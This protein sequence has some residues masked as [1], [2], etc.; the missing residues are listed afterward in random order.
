LCWAGTTRA[1]GEL[2]AR[3]W[4]SVGV[5]YRV[6]YESIHAARDV[7]VSP[8]VASATS[9]ARTRDTA[10]RAA[11]EGGGEPGIA[12]GGCGWATVGMAR[13]RRRLA[14]S[15]H[16]SDGRHPV[17][18]TEGRETA[19]LAMARGIQ[20][21]GGRRRM[22]SQSAS[23]SEAWGARQEKDGR[24]PE[25]L[26][27]GVASVMVMV[28]HPASQLGCVGCPSGPPWFEH[29]P[30]PGGWKW[31]WPGWSVF[32]PE[33]SSGQPG[34]SARPATLGSS[35]VTAETPG[36]THPVILTSAG[37]TSLFEGASS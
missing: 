37:P 20:I 35:F 24:D 2:S 28:K 5:P 27:H 33:P 15:R 26:L 31:C 25:K 10:W 36:S 34:R 14:Q 16:F 3:S 13:T 1:G 17:T 18:A 7:S 6:S 4:F 22:R 30:V 32:E 9:G 11:A 29:A 8:R 19:G 23:A 21:M 12:W